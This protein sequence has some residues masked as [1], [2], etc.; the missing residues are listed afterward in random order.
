[1]FLHKGLSLW[2]T[3]LE[4]T[5]DVDQTAGVTDRMGN[6]ESELTWSKVRKFLFFFPPTQ[7]IDPFGQSCL[8]FHLTLLSI[9]YCS[10]NHCQALLAT[11]RVRSFLCHLYP[12]AAWETFRINGAL[13]FHAHTTRVIFVLS[14]HL[15]LTF[16]CGAK[17]I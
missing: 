4:G 16:F 3:R 11:Y 15:Y 5:A 13:T 14:S 1:M 6:S 7:A 8:I 10:K 17:E 2:L 12:S 9:I